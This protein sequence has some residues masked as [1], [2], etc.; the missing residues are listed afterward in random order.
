MSSPRAEAR[1]KRETRTAAT[2]SRS[3]LFQSLLPL[4]G[5]KASAASAHGPRE[6]AVAHAQCTPTAATVPSTAVRLS[7]SRG[8]SASS[9]SSPP[10]M[11]R[12][13]TAGQARR[14]PTKRPRLWRD[15]TS[16]I[17]RLRGTLR[18]FSPEILT[19]ATVATVA[20]SYM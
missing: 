5:A 2:R 11:S 4:L 18:M 12:R 20:R 15:K 13:L 3:L 9:T 8:A 6:A 16:A 17:S 10:R 14:K 1:R 7:N 19:P